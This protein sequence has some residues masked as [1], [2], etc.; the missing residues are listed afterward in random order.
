MSDVM[1]ALR[2]G[3][4]ELHQR[5]ES[6]EFQRRMARGELSR[7]EYAAWLGQMLLVHR[8][9][10]TAL[11]AARQSDRRFEPVVVEHF[12]EGHLR[13]D[14][15]ALGAAE[16]EPLEA[17]RRI[18]ARIAQSGAEQPLRLL[19]YH[20]VLEGSMNGNRFL[21]R[22]LG[23]A[24]GLSAGQGDRYL[25]PYGERQREVWARFKQEMAQVGFAVDERD[26][27][28]EAAREMFA[29]ITDLSA[30]LASGAAGAPALSARAG[31]DS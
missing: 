19:G 11:R 10:E 4:A 14:L 24:L 27:L 18:L 7:P 17:T 25:D 8:A 30:E 23:P 3:T 29:A 22:R 9:L 12:K 26:V 16:A 5:A 20:Y 6:Q 21:A 15:S 28:V 13:A 1:E 31:G 2:L